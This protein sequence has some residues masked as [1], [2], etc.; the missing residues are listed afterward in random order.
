MMEGVRKEDYQ[1]SNMLGVELSAKHY[2]N[3]ESN[4]NCD[5]QKSVESREA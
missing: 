1:F 3:Q 2:H 5:E 4:K